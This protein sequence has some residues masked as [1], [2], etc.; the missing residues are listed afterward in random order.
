MHRETTN[1]DARDVMTAYARTRH[2]LDGYLAA[3]LIFFLYTF[4]LGSKTTFPIPKQHK[5]VL[6]SLSGLQI[7][8]EQQLEQHLRASLPGLT[9]SNA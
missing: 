3:V 6:I 8:T 9:E 7:K 5:V 4:F 1:E 2:R